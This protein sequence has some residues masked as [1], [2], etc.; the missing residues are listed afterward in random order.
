MIVPWVKFVRPY[1]YR[2][3][4]RAMIAYKPGEYLVPEKC[5]RA[6]IAAGA[7]EAVDDPGEA[8]KR[9]QNAR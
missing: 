4:A 5:K 8:R 3:S 6:A 2:A 7:A 1:D 9:K